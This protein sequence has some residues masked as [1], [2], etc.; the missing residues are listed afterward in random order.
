MRRTIGAFT[1]SG[2]S[3]LTLRTKGGYRLQ[4]AI[5]GARA[6]GTVAFPAGVSHTFSA[7][8]VKRPFGLYGVEIRDGGKR[9]L[10]GWI[11]LPG[12]RSRGAVKS[13]GRIVE[14]STLNFIT[15]ITQL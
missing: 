9:Y 1:G 4:V 3:S 15:P 11:V 6:T 10:G 12:G 14:S 2:T 13:G 7:V 8:S 5:A